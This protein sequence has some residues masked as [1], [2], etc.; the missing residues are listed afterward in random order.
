[1]DTIHLSERIITSDFPLSLSLGRLPA[2]AQYTATKKLTYTGV[3]QPKHHIYLPNA[4]IDHE[5][6]LYPLQIHD[7]V[8]ILQVREGKAAVYLTNQKLDMECGDICILNPY[9]PHSFMF[10]RDIAC[11]RFCIVFFPNQLLNTA[12]SLPEETAV[13]FL[14]EQ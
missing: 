5:G 8:E 1:M 2:D 7:G 14:Q 13:R 12:Y 11:E 3:F 6:R 4:S 9:E 10:Y